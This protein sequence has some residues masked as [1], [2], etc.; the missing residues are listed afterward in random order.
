MEFYEQW[1]NIMP[2]SVYFPATIRVQQ[3]ENSEQGAH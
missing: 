2:W 3:R 1:L